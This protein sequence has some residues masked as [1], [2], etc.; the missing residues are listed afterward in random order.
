MQITILMKFI[1]IAKMRTD[2]CQY[3]PNYVQ[4]YIIFQTDSDFYIQA[5]SFLQSA[6]MTSSGINLYF[7]GKTFQVIPGK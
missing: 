2:L 6:Y 5:I 4:L 1:L 7:L 3:K